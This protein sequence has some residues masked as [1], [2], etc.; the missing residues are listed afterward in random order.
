MNTAKSPVVF[1][2]GDPEP[3]LSGGIMDYIECLRMSKWYEPPIPPAG[4]ARAANAAVH[5]ASAMNLKRN[6][7]TALFQPH[8]ALS[9]A[10]FYRFVQDFLLFGNAYLERRDNR[11]GKLL[12][13]TPPLAKYM[14]RGAD[15]ATYFY[16]PQWGIEHPFPKGAIFHLLESDV[17]QDIYGTPQYLPALNSAFLNESATLFRRRYYANG[18]HAGFILYLNDATQSDADIENLREALKNSKGPGNFRNLFV[19]APNGKKDGLQLIPVSEVAAKDEFLNI[20]NVTRD[21]QLAAHRIPP[22]LL[23]IIPANTGGFGDVEKS[24]WVFYM[25]EIR[26]LMALMQEINTWVEDEVVTFRPYDIVSGG[27]PNP[28]LK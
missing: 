11:L 14:R 4:L 13:L 15:L 23:G 6:M 28:V 20:K 12:S 18:S 8:P 2:F 25:N 21:D 24:A 19:Y 5:H 3:V 26:P 16:V 7:L 9:R 1:A 17:N 10:S 22:Q 27:H